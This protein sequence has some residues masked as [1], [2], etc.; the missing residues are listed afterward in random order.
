MSEPKY[1]EW[2]VG[3]CQMPTNMVMRANH[4]LINCHILTKHILVVVFLSGYF[5]GDTY[6]YPTRHMSFTY[7]QCCAL[8]E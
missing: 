1:E 2:Y 5:C 8:T 3:I 6:S 4:P 7:V